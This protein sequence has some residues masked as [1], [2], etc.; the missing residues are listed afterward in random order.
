MNYLKLLGSKSLAKEKQILKDINIQQK[1]KDVASFK[2][3][4]VLKETVIYFSTV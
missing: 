3:L 4:E 1:E 2:S